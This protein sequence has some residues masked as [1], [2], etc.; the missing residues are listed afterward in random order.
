MCCTQGTKVE[1]GPSAGKEVSWLTDWQQALPGHE[2]CLAE[3]CRGVSEREQGAAA[4][5]DVHLQGVSG[6]MKTRT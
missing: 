3:K 1:S 5:T 2:I 6:A 4:T